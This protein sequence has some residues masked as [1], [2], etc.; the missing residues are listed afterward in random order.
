MCIR[1]SS[2]VALDEAGENLGLLD[3]DPSDDSITVD[4]SVIPT[5]AFSGVDV[6]GGMLL[7]WSLLAAATFVALIGVAFRR[8]RPPTGVRVGVVGPATS[9]FGPAA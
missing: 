3:V 6:D 2:S 8:R 4:L 1:D 5:L 9:R 7:G